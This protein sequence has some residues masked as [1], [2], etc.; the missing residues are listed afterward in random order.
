LGFEQ[1]THGN[2]FSFKQMKEIPDHRSTGI[3][4]YRLDEILL[5]TQVGVLCWADDMAIRTDRHG[6]G[7]RVFGWRVIAAIGIRFIRVTR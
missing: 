2:P 3:G 7:L 6:V 1:E 5:A 4:P